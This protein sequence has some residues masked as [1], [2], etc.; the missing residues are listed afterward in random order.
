MNAQE[1]KLTESLVRELKRLNDNLA[2]GQLNIR[3]H[4]PLCVAPPNGDFSVR[5]LEVMSSYLH[6]SIETGALVLPPKDGG[7]S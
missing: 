3:T 2:S 6:K 4:T 5:Q 1:F 7:L